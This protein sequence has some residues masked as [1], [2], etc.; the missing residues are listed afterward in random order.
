[1]F[2]SS[3]LTWLLVEVDL[4]GDGGLE[5]CRGYMYFM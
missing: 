2:M 4:G 1:L 3:S 5:Y